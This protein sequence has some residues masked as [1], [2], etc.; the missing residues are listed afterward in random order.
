MV[1]KKFQVFISSTFTDLE[2]ERQAAGHAIL[3]AGHIPVG[4]EFFI[5]GKPTEKII[6]ESIKECDIYMLL[7]GKRYG[8]PKGDTGFG[9]THWEF[10]RAI[11]LKKPWFALLL[12]E[13]GGT[14]KSI[15]RD[16]EDEI[17]DYMN[18]NAFVKEVKSTGNLYARWKNKEDIISEVVPILNQMKDEYPNLAGWIK[19][20]EI[21]K[22]DK[23][24]KKLE[25]KNE[26]LHKIIDRVNE[27]PDNNFDCTDFNEFCELLTDSTIESEKL[28]RILSP[29]AEKFGD[30]APNY[31]H[32][33]WYARDKLFE[34]FYFKDPD[35]EYPE[36]EDYEA[37]IEERFILDELKRETL[38]SEDTDPA[39][40]T[41]FELT[42]PNGQNF[43]VRML[44]NF[45]DKR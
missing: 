11:E 45:R 27:K 5:A 24:I 32:Y 21:P 28:K 25:D 6:E 1:K 30:T 22:K 9:Y 2:K 38:V 41:N 3:K 4:M 7:L 14:I 12:E 39:A 15:N 26:R 23:H 42:V 19:A 33:L 20:D 29:I 17:R 10:K 35:E 43:Y 31:L 40:A 37:L 16:D 13:Q 8:S 34:G 18:L 36:N 44:V